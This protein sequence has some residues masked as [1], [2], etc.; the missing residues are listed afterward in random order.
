[1]LN[2]FVS[3][4]SKVSIKNLSA[5]D[6]QSRMNFN[7]AKSHDAVY[8]PVDGTPGPVSRHCYWNPTASGGYHHADHQLDT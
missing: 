1:M 4:K 2:N 6:I 3:S 5:Q 7:I 8:N